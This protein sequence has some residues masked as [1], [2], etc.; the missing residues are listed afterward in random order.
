[1]KLKLSNQQLILIRFR[2]EKLKEEEKE[3]REKPRD[4]IDPWDLVALSNEESTLKDLLEN[5]YI[6]LNS[7]H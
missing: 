3:L 7:I 5:E 6:D 4:T 2:L 1:M